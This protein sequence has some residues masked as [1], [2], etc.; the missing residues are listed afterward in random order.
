MAPTSL[1]GSNTIIFFWF[2]STRTTFHTHTH[3]HKHVNNQPAEDFIKFH[4]LYFW[5]L[6]FVSTK[7]TLQVE[8]KRN[9]WEK[10]VSTL[11]V[12]GATSCAG[13]SFHQAAGFEGQKAG[14]A[15]YQ[16]EAMRKYE[17]V[18]LSNVLMMNLLFIYY[19]PARRHSNWQK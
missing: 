9:E 4:K 10:M 1:L 3:T 8:K 2:S 18:I 5:A 7:A 6:G 13:G 19:V 15:W 11:A 12:L 16:T 14:P 17:T